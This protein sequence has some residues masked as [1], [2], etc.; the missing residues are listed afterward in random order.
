MTRNELRTVLQLW[1][2][3]KV[4]SRVD[5]AKILMR[6]PSGKILSAYESFASYRINIYHSAGVYNEAI[7]W[8]TLNNYLTRQM[9]QLARKMEPPYYSDTDSF[10]SKFTEEELEEIKTIYRGGASHA[11]V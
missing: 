3:W 4:N 10:I 11:K 1:N 8:S 9:A 6:M 5:Y 2:A 7:S